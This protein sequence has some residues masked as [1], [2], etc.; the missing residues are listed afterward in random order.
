M[1]KKSITWKLTL[2]FMTIVIISTLL[3]GLIALNI[4]KNN[5]YET[6]RSNMS[7]HAQEILQ[8]LKPSTNNTLTIEK[9][10]N[11]IKPADSFMG[12]KLWILDS[13]GQ[14]IDFSKGQETD[15]YY[16]SSD[17]I[18]KNYK[19]I[20]EKVSEGTS[21]SKE[22]YNPYYDE[23]MMTLALPIKN[24]ENRIVGALFLHSSIEDLSNSM[25]K[26][27]IYLIIALFAEIIL[28]GFMTYYFSKSITKPIKA[29]KDSAL[30]M[31]RGNYGIKTGIY[32]E[33]EIGEL[34]NS[35]DLLSLKL[36][37][38]IEKLSEE[39]TKLSNVITSMNEGLMAL[40]LKFK[41]I[42]INK[43]ALDILMLHHNSN[44][45]DI[46]S[47]LKE[48]DLIQELKIVLKSGNAKALTKTYNNKIL[49]FSISPIINSF[50]NISGT[51][52][53][54][55]DISE[56]ERL[57]QMRKDFIANVS[58]EFRTPLTIIRG[59][60]ESI[61]DE[62]VPQEDMSDYHNTILKETYRLERM[63][64]D[65][66]DLSKLESGKVELNLQSID[67]NMIIKDTLR[68]MR[69]LINSKDIVIKMNLQE[70]MPP[71]FSDYDKLKQLLIIFIDNSIKFSHKKGEIVLST[72][73]ENENIFISIKD[74]GI[75][76][77]KGDLPYLGERFYKVDKSRNFLKDGNG[78]GLSI[79]KNLVKIL[80]GNF[81]VESEIDNG[82]IVKIN[83][84]ISNKI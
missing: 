35:F 67:V 65:L 25:D 24:A 26:F 69:T 82:T 40:D 33:D 63:V 43:S 59:N 21:L 27:F 45:Q 1:F 42:N 11:I 58:H 54:I 79:A 23:Y 29:I 4:F 7:K 13:K 16:I 50:N 31:S 46:Y 72:F 41:I 19:D 44:E 77:P 70:K 51:V 9:C 3:I 60:V 36:K 12:L 38:T 80:N 68:S 34:S 57:E 48:L 20:I 84:P 49:S 76:I 74:N 83:F 55:E 10:K 39:K 28:A 64:K 14:L 8:N 15:I 75:G 71:L 6:K 32:Q 62:I 22:L 2:G 52:I 5:I 61:V 37:Y 17:E 66:L 73:L 47:V 81:A 18:Y 56:K 78:I 30:S 53:V